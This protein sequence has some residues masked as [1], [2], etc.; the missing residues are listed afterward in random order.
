MGEFIT[1]I[2]EYYGYMA[3]YIF[4]WNFA[5]II[6]TN[7]VSVATGHKFTFGKRGY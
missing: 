3:P 2:A 1:F 7:I 5:E 6:V 4:V